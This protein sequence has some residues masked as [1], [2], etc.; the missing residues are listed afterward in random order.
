[1]L[2]HAATGR[3]PL[4]AARCGLCECIG[5]ATLTLA[6]G[7]SYEGFGLVRHYS[8]ERGYDRTYTVRDHTLLSI[9][10]G[11]HTYVTAPGYRQYDLWMLAGDGRSRGV[12]L[13]PEVGW[14]QKIVEMVLGAWLV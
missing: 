7:G 12:T 5:F 1:V 13:D 11:C 6:A 10:H 9:P 2:S 14:T 3:G 8:P 4:G